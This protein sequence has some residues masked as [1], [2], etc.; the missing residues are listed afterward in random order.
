MSQRAT[1]RLEFA[2]PAR[3]R[4]SMLKW[5]NRWLLGRA[6]RRLEAEMTRP[7]PRRPGPDDSDDGIGVPVPTGPRPRRDGALAQPPQPV[8]S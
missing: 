3:A 4:W 6:E 2:L 7:S 5:L 8:E 1:Q